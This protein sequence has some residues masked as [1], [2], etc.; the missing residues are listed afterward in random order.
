MS[1]EFCYLGTVSSLRL[2]FPCA[3]TVCPAMLRVG[4]VREEGFLV[5]F[6]FIRLEECGSVSARSPMLQTTL[7]CESLAALIS[8][9]KGSEEWAHC[10]HA[11]HYL[12]DWLRKLLGCASPLTLRGLVF[13]VPSMTEVD[14]SCKVFDAESYVATC[15]RQHGRWCILRPHASVGRWFVHVEGFQ[16]ELKS[17]LS[18]PRGRL[19]DPDFRSSAIKL[20]RR[21]FPQASH[22]RSLEVDGVQGVAVDFLFVFEEA[23]GGLWKTRGLQPFCADEGEQ[24]EDCSLHA[25]ICDRLLQ[26][27]AANGRLLLAQRFNQGIQAQCK[28][29]V[30]VSVDS[31]ELPCH[32]RWRCVLACEDLFQLRCEYKKGL[33]TVHREPPV[34][35][36][37][38]DATLARAVNRCVLQECLAGVQKRCVWLE[39]TTVFGY[40]MDF[41]FLTLADGGDKYRA[42][43]LLN[44][45]WRCFPTLRILLQTLRLDA[46][47]PEHL[48][49]EALSALA[50]PHTYHAGCLQLA[51]L[52]FEEGAALC[53][54][55]RLLYYGTAIASLGT[56][57]AH[58]RF[59]VTTTKQQ[60][61][62]EGL[63][64][65]QACRVLQELME[66]QPAQEERRRPRGCYGGVWAALRD[67]L[68]MPQR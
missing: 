39:P 48:L 49:S 54:R 15:K 58:G 66:Q 10:T 36:Q 50:W 61:K 62:Y 29:A 34:P 46:A 30:Q 27:T 43:S 42:Y 41:V 12:R 44:D 68:C 21:E 5:D 17:I 47:C 56:S 16:K 53:W 64:F 45:T 52:R 60:L 51:H 63:P 57:G 28:G 7:R 33:F 24:A 37:E 31:L 25:F 19:A 18:A 32:E 65:A 9:L 55:A 35:L 14:W 20:L 6:V 2:A 13:N 1:D 26:L 67:Q 8:Q 3:R 23:P 59:F 11:E 22:V 40:Q 4:D 38:L